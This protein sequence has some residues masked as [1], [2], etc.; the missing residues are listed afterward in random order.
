[1]FINKVYGLLGLPTYHFLVFHLN[2][3]L[4]F[5][6]CN[7]IFLIINSDLFLYYLIEFL[8]VLFQ[9]QIAIIFKTHINIW[10]FKFLI[11]PTDIL[12]HIPNKHLLLTLLKSLLSPLFFIIFCYYLNINYFCGLTILLLRRW[13]VFYIFG[14]PLFT[15]VVILQS[16]FLLLKYWIAFW[17]LNWQSIC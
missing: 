9:D 14:Y 11:I 2:I 8:L 1:M 17:K 10:W 3:S 13:P 4:I 6:F 12:S 15:T 5:S 16:L 7:K